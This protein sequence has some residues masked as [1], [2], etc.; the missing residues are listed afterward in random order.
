MIVALAPTAAANAANSAPNT[1]RN[2]RPLTAPVAPDQPATIPAQG[3]GSGAHGHRLEVNRPA[4]EP[5]VRVPR[6]TIT[7]GDQIAR[8]P[9]IFDVPAPM[10]PRFRRWRNGMRTT[11]LAPELQSEIGPDAQVMSRKGM[12][13]PYVVVEP[14]PWYDSFSRTIGT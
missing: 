11:L 1:S 5:V 13:T 7:A 12:N 8:I 9:I 3:R 6:R 4:V 2:M 10:W 14:G